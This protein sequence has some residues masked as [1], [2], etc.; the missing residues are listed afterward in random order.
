MKDFENPFEYDAALNLP[1][2][3]I[4][5]VYVED[6][7]YTRFIQSTKNVFLHGE[8]GS[9]KSMTLIYNSFNLR[10]LKALSKDKEIDFSLIGIYI[11][12]NTSLTHNQNYLLLTDAF[13]SKIISEHF[14]SLQ[15]VSSFA[16][17]LS[18]EPS[19]LNGVN[20]EELIEDLSYIL[21]A[22]LP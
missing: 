12:C 19:L 18:I 10:R 16:E 6:Y 7:N 9:G 1:E 11:P 4:L 22:D 13:Q 14:L 20:Q 5:A 3:M 17:S 2:E 21:S 8:R 15:I